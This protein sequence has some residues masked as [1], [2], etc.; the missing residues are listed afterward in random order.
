MTPDERLKVATELLQSDPDAAHKLCQDIL[1]DDPECAPAN[2]LLGVISTRAERYG[3]ALAFFYRAAELK[4]NRAEMWNN[5]GTVYHELKKP[6]K[7]REY[8]KRALSL[9]EDPMY[10][11]NIGVTYSDEGEHAEALKWIQ[12][13]A[14]SGM[15]PAIANAAAFA[16]LSL[17]QWAEGWKHYEATLGGRFRKQLDFG[18]SDW[19][20]KKTGTLVVYGEQG[21]GDE[22]MYG[23]IIPDVRE[24]CDRLIIECDPRLES[25]YRRSFPYAEVYGTRRMDR[26]W[27]DGLKV[28]AQ[29]ACASLPH[30]FRPSP[31]SCPRVPYLTADPERRVMW[32]ALFDSWKK[33][34]IGLTWSGGR[35]A[36]QLNKRTMGLESLRPLIESTDAVFVS[37]QYEDPSEEIERSGLPVRWFPETMKDRSLDDAAALIAELDGQIGIHTTAHHLAGALGKPSKVFVP[38]APMWLYS[39]GDRIPF[40]QSQTF[41]RQKKD[42]RWIDCVR[43]SLDN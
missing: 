27:L 17:G 5:L 37:L 11:A 23:S 8:F 41:F 15:T 22:I 34:V 26:P 24:L 14:K 3:A 29:I 19:D 28:N 1:K 36:S 12:K 7:A 2:V 30:L 42:E 20:G 40:Y 32:R 35:F 43:R 25:L 18:G 9:K 6:A 33:P 4:P 13:A 21:I 16:H 10:L 38:T 31:D 39:F